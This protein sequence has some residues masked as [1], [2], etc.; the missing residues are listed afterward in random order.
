MIV[1]R[2]EIIIINYEYDAIN[3][4]LGVSQIYRFA[5]DLFPIRILHTYLLKGRALQALISIKIF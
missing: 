5:K 1:S 2:Y 4:F 3:A